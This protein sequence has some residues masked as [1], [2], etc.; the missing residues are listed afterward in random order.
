M[1][2][3]LGSAGFLDASIEY[4]DGDRA[5]LAEGRTRMVWALWCCRTETDVSVEQDVPIVRAV[6]CVVGSQ[7]IE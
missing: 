1:R 5:V 7:A 4:F 2:L 6:F 3:S